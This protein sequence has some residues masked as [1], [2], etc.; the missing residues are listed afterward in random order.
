MCGPRHVNRVVG[1]EAPLGLWN[2][3]ALIEARDGLDAVPRW[4]RA[5]RHVPAP[6][7]VLQVRREG[8]DGP[9]EAGVRPWDGKMLVLLDGQTKSSGES[10][11]WMLQHALRGR[12]IGARTAGMIEYGN[13]VLYVLPAS[14]LH[15]GLTTK[16]NDYGVA[17]ELD[18]L[19]VQTET[20]SQNA[21][22][23]VARAFEH[24][25]TQHPAAS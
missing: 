7:D 5:H 21:L 3:A 10:A 18:G 23:T 15:I 14:G 19:P 8:D 4:H 1:R 12:L 2:S 11:A 24:L 13:I 25:C 20:G 17:I 22:T 6:G 9:L 16:H